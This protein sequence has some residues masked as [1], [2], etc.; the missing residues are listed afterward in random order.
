MLFTPRRALLAEPVSFL[1]FS[2]NNLLDDVHTAVQKI[3]PPSTK[4]SLRTPW[5]ETDHTLFNAVVLHLDEEID[6]DLVDKLTSIPQ[7]EQAWQVRRY[8]SPE[9]TTKK[10]KVNKKT[11]VADTFSPHVMMGID[12]LH[13]AGHYGEGMLGEYMLSHSFTCTNNVHVFQSVSL[14]LSVRLSES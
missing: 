9:S 2:V 11:A 3:L 5:N 6:S 4:P 1:Q 8:I 14:T 12:K 13:K 7:V 10:S